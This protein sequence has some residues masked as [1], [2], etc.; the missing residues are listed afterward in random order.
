MGVF[1]APVLG[2]LDTFGVRLV[3][4]AVTG[5]TPGSRIVITGGAEAGALAIG[6]VVVADGAESGTTSIIVADGITEAG[7]TAVFVGHGGAEAGATLLSVVDVA[8]SGPIF[9]ER[10]G[11]QGATV[12]GEATEG[13]AGGV[14]GIEEDGKKL[15]T[16][17]SGFDHAEGAGGELWVGRRGDGE[18]E[19]FSIDGG[20]TA[21]VD[22]IGEGGGLHGLAGREFGLSGSDVGEHCAGE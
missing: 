6:G 15:V 17:L 22:A 2:I 20:L 16:E 5:T 19:K 8:L 9:G 12:G 3:C 14:A 13:V 7:T 11:E 18:E 1:I 10:D 4:V 21:D